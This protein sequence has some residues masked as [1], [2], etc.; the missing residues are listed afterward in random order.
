M[1]LLGH[2]LIKIEGASNSSSWLAESVCDFRHLVPIQ[3]AKVGDSNAL[4]ACWLGRQQ[5]CLKRC[6]P[7]LILVGRQSGEV[8]PLPCVSLIP[9]QLQYGLVGRLAIVLLYVRRELAAAVSDRESQL[10]RITL[11]KAVILDL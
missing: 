4:Q 6:S 10:P 8:L 11:R 3:T 2:R 7:A 9:R 1:A 5:T